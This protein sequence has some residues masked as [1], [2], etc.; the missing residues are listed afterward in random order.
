MSLSSIFIPPKEHSSSGLDL[1]QNY[2]LFGIKSRM[3]LLLSGDKSRIVYFLSGIKFW[4]VLFLVQRASEGRGDCD[5]AENRA[6]S[7]IER[8]AVGMTGLRHRTTTPRRWG[9]KVMERQFWGRCVL[10]WG[11]KKERRHLG[12]K[13]RKKDSAVKWGVL[14]RKNILNSK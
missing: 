3:V 12:K 7:G 1:W 10:T 8:G 2:I 6:C 13:E 9:D 5:G 4:M 11:R 14:I